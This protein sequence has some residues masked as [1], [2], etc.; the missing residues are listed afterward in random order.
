MTMTPMFTAK[1][2]AANFAA[3]ET[4][5]DQ[6]SFQALSYIGEEFVN[7][8]RRKTK[9]EGGFGNV[10]HNLRGSIGYAILYDGEIKT[11]DLD[12]NA[13]GQ[14]AATALISELASKHNKGWILIGF[15]GMEY[16][17]A[18]ESM[19]YDV[20]TGSVPSNLKVTNTIEEL[21]G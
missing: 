11:K 17:A 4:L 12:G 21:L 19:G 8:A 20:I 14:A 10:T 16:A 7:A 6:D 18:V 1:I 2:I 15:A 13:E 3:F 5:V 9:A